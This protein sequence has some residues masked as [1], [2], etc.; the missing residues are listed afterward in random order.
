MQMENEREIFHLMVHSLNGCN[1]QAKTTSL[2]L[3]CDAGITGGNLTCC[4]EA[5]AL[6]SQKYERALT[7]SSIVCSLF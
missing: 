3:P 6:G 5:L 1:D 4:F 7:V 2:E